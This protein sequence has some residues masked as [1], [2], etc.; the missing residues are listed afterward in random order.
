[1]AP[2]IERRAANKV[3]QRARRLGRPVTTKWPGG[4]MQRRGRA[5]INEPTCISTQAG[6]K[7]FF[8]V[9]RRFSRQTERQ[10]AAGVRSFAFATHG[11]RFPP[12]PDPAPL[13]GRD[14]TALADAWRIPAPRRRHR[15]ALAPCPGP[16][17]ARI[18]RSGRGRDRRWPSGNIGRPAPRRESLTPKRQRCPRRPSLARHDGQSRAVP[19]IGSVFVSRASLTRSR[20]SVDIGLI[21]AQRGER[22]A[23]APGPRGAQ[24]ECT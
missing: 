13:R 19:S 5:T 10:L 6:D 18:C 11:V 9:A 23:P 20:A 21:G 17:G 16:P 12:P 3:M 4:G 1:M 14:R 8:K 22:L 7:R 15:P 24:K 2:S